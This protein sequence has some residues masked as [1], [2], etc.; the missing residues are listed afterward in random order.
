[1][2]RGVAEEAG[3]GEQGGLLAQFKQ[4][5]GQGSMAIQLGMMK[6]LS[7]SMTRPQ[8]LNR[9]VGGKAAQKP[10]SARQDAMRAGVTQLSARLTGEGLK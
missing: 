6:K 7:E 1:M 4:L 9:W 8:A 10:V 3:G 2:Y 5:L